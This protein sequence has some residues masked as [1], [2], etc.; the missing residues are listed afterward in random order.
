MLDLVLEELEVRRAQ[1]ES[2]PGRATLRADYQRALATIGKDVRIEQHDGTVEGRAHGVDHA[3]HLLVDVDG[4]D[5]GLWRGR[6]RAPSSEE[7]ALVS[8]PTR[9]LVTGA[10]GQV[11]V[12]LMDVLNG[13]TPPGGDP[14]FQPDGRAVEAGE[15]EALGLTHHELDV[16]DRDEVS[17][18]LAAARPDV[19]VHLAA[20]TAVDRAE[21][22]AERCFEVNEIGTLVMSHAA[23]DVGRTFHHHLDGLRL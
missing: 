6:R 23:R 8:R 14:T 13:V 9:V 1:L 2:E 22:D 10:G 17:R 11:G 19:V 20:Y 7:R 16:T 3:G 15:F 5:S 12:D 4:R 18:A 21:E